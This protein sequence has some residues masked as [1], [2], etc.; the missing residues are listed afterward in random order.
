MLSLSSSKIPKTFLGLVDAGSSHCFIETKFVREHSLVTLAVDPLSLSLIDGSVNT[1]VSEAV[2]IPVRFPTGETLQTTFYVTTLNSTCSVVLGHNWLTCHNPL[3]DWVLG[4][5]SFRKTKQE[6]NRHGFTSAC[7]AQALTPISEP[8][9]ESASEPSAST[10][11]P[12]EPENLNGVPAEYHDFADV[13]SK[14]RADT[15]APHRPYDLKINLEEGASPPIRSMYSL[16]AKETEALREFID[17][18]LNI[19]FIHPSRS[20]H[21]APVLFVRKKD[22][23]LRLC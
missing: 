23:S 13:F 11:P 12:N 21:G 20:S 3:I 6:E 1:V 4:T 9:S 8:I 19:G 17:E 7:F 15:L 18:H 5:V 2:T 14:K 16:S 22:G 10:A